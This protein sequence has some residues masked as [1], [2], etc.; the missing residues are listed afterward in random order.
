ME[1]EMK[2]EKQFSSARELFEHNQQQIIEK[3]E[4]YYDKVIDKFHLTTWKLDL[5]VILLIVI[6]VLIFVFGSKR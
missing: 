5:L 6:I 1:E 3:K 2:E 4:A